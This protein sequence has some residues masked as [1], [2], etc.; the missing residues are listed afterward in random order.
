MSAT[1][2]SYLDGIVWQYFGAKIQ[3]LTPK[4]TI[5]CIYVSVGCSLY[6][7]LH[8]SLRKDKFYN[9]FSRAIGTFRLY[10]SCLKLSIVCKIDLS[11]HDL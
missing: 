3:P 6:F 1:L 10:F 11:F 8:F 7:L 2:F 5:F 9:T 4:Q